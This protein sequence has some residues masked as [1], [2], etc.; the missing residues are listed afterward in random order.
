MDDLA[1]SEHLLRRIFAIYPEF[2]SEWQ[3]DHQDA[4]STQQSPH[5]VHMSLFPFAHF[6]SSSPKQLASLAA[7]L[8]EAVTAGG[9]AENAVVTCFLEHLGTSPLRK[10]IWPLLH[11]ATK[12]RTR[13]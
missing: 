1:L 6:T 7:L 5:S 12:Q 2:E 11:L 8:N 4:A 13:A 10:A 9:V 3:A